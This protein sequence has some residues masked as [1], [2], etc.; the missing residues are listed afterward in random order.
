MQK[1]TWQRSHSHPN[2]LQTPKPR[3]LPVSEVTKSKLGK[4]KYDV[5]HDSEQPQQDEGAS[6][7]TPQAGHTTTPIGR[8]N[9]RDLVEPSPNVEDEVVESPSDRIMWDSKRESAFAAGLSPMVGRKGKKRAR[10]SSPVSSPATEKPGAP[11]VNVKKLAKALRSPHADPTLELW[12][13]YSLTNNESPALAVGFTN[14][15]LAQL[16]ISSSPRPPKDGA[17]AR[18][19]SSLRRTMSAGIQSLK[20]RKIEKQLKPGSQ[21]SRGQRDLEAASKSSLVSALLE[22]VTSSM[23]DLSQGE[24]PATCT[25]E[26]PTPAR[27]AAQPTVKLEASTNSTLDNMDYF[28]D[29]F[30]DAYDDDALM[31]ME[32]T[33][34]STALSQTPS[35]P[36]RASPK[37]TVPKPEPK[38]P[39]KNLDEFDDLEE[40][41]F[42]DDLLLADTSIPKPIEP[43]LEKR[44]PVAVLAD[45]FDDEFGDDIAEEF[46]IEA[47]EFAAT[48]TT[49]KNSSN[50][51]TVCTSRNGI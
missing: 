32:K 29:D 35:K 36:A 7:K 11:S 24:T 33:V 8:L 9:W 6:T 42:D 43:K 31:E 47:M 37:T 44:E 38:A 2:G 30:D 15:S 13:R 25:A 39:A 41:A 4:F 16:V 19:G 1:S 48:Q 34:T 46:D 40:D 26:S 20:R 10:S 23:Q 27:R 5:A 14:P 50:I 12:D 49:K 45:E 28:D 51:A 17:P 21:G 3:P 22:T 18:S